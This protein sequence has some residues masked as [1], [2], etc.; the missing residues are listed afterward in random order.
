[1]YRLLSVV[2]ACL[3]SP[4]ARVRIEFFITACRYNPTAVYMYT[5]LDLAHFGGHARHILSTWVKI[6]RQRNYRVFVGEPSRSS[7]LSLL[8][9]DVYSSP[10]SVFSCFRCF[11]FF[12][13]LLRN[14]TGAFSFFVSIKTRFPSF[15]FFLLFSPVFLRFYVTIRAAR[16][17]SRVLRRTPSV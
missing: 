10:P 16:A 7:M 2:G 1:M 11:S 4:P 14:C 6:Y 17:S 13:L 8:F 5:Y 12:Q 9:C 3:I 15:S